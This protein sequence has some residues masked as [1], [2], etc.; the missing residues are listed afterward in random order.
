MGFV[1]EVHCGKKHNESQE[2]HYN[3]VSS[4]PV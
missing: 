4:S 2:N 3:L 1:P